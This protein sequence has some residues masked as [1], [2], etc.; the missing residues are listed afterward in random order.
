MSFE[1]IK[2]EVRT[3]IDNRWGI[4]LIVSWAVFEIF[5]IWDMIS[6]FRVVR[7]VP[8]YSLLGILDIVL[9]FSIVLYFLVPIISRNVAI[10]KGLL[11]LAVGVGTL[12]LQFLITV[13]AAAI[14]I[15]AIRWSYFIIL[16]S[17]IAIVAFTIL[18][19]NVRFKITI[20]E[21][22]SIKTK[23]AV[24]E[25]VENNIEETSHD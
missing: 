24:E 8:I 3:M 15:L 7:F 2:S 23:Q 19:N 21:E 12:V 13:L 14:F 4:G 11:Y 17:E 16:L 18:L 6:M 10:H 1:D 5:V 9:L 20:P 25:L 22:E